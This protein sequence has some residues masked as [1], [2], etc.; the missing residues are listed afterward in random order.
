M[1]I[2]TPMFAY[3]FPDPFEYREEWAGFLRGIRCL[4]RPTYRSLIQLVD[5][6]ERINDWRGHWQEV[7]EMGE[8]LDREGDYSRHWQQVR[9]LE[10]I[11]KVARGRLERII[12]STDWEEVGT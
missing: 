9:R 2:P 4:R 11:Y 8:V 6:V 12:A 1:K 7:A 10:R 5:A 3:R